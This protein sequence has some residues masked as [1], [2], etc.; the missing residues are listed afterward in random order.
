MRMVGVGDGVSGRGLE[1][2][3]IIT[4]LMTHVC[5]HLLLSFSFHFYSAIKLGW[6]CLYDTMLMCSYL[7]LLVD[8]ICKL[9]LCVSWLGLLC[10]CTMGWVA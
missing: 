9:N 5:Q 3:F 2:T 4:N 10:Q 6:L 7:Q 1:A 8:L